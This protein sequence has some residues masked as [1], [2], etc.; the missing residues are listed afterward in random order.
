M[1]NHVKVS[2]ICLSYNA[3]HHIER[4]VENLRSQTLAEIEMIFVDNAS[5]DNTVKVLQTYAEKD[6]RIVIVP[7]KENIFSGGLNNG[8]DIAKGEYILIVGDDDWFDLDFLE[9]MYQKG[10]EA[11]ADLVISGAKVEYES[12]ELEKM[13]PM[14]L[15]DPS[16]FPDLDQPMSGKDYYEHSL[17]HKIHPGHTATILMKRSLLYENNIKFYNNSHYF[18]D[19]LFRTHVFLTAQKVS[20]VPDTFFHYFIRSNSSMRNL[21]K[22]L[23]KK[24]QYLRHYWVYIQEE[25]YLYHQYQVSPKDYPSIYGMMKGHR[26]AYIKQY[27]ALYPNT[28]PNQMLTAMIQHYRMLQDKPFVPFPDFYLKESDLPLERENMST[29]C[30]FGAGEEGER[31]LELFQEKSLAMPV[32]IC[33]NDLSKQGKTMK[34]IPILSLESSLTQYPNASFLV[35]NHH[36]YEEILLQIYE[37]V[38]NGKIFKLF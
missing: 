29:L 27:L 11:Q 23:S 38:E 24:K 1:K 15:K 5:Q 6:N 2:I 19:N 30:F 25:T 28:N 26:S 13:Y 36:Y 4:I 22:E 20:F 35:T 14:H 33:D 32:A 10:N 8:I 9:K 3:E 7:R 21:D 37:K 18:S 31:V 12:P 34:D 16:Q 17:K